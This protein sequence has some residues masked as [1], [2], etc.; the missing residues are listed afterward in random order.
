VGGDTGNQPGQAAKGSLLVVFNLQKNKLGDH[1]DQIGAVE[2]THPPDVRGDV[3]P[4]DVT[5]DH[6]P[7]I[8]DFE[9]DDQ[10]TG[11][12]GGD[13]EKYRPFGDGGEV[14]R[15]EDVADRRD[16]AQTGGGDHEKHIG[17]D[18]DAPGHLSTDSKGVFV[19]GDQGM[20]PGGH[21]DNAEQRE[22]AHDHG[23]FCRS[24]RLQA[25]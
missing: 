11:D 9:G 1:K 19:S 15:A 6:S 16:N 22:N 10:E 20:N 14:F 13:G 12:D 24:T 17:G 7:G 21:A 25:S 5:P 23:E 3:G 18:E 4:E 8:R 2:G